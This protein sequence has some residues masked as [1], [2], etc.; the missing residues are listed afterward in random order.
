MSI[1]DQHINK[2]HLLDAP[3]DRD[4]GAVASTSEYA[5]RESSTLNGLGAS[6]RLRTSACWWRLFFGWVGVNER[7]IYD[8]ATGK[9]A[10]TIA[11]RS[12]FDDKFKIDAAPITPHPYCFRKPARY[13]S[14]NC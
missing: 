11:R 1:P 14:V 2:I 13:G 3:V 12:A 9:H 5:L 6:A 7:R 4:R 10:W 8:F